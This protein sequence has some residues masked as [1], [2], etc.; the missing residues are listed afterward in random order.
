[1]LAALLIVSIALLTV[2]FGEGASGPI[3]TIQR[4][5]GSVAAPIEKGANRALK[6]ARDLFGW[7][8][9]SVTAKGDNDEL[10]TEV[11]ELRTR[12]AEAQDQRSEN[13]KLREFVGLRKRPDFPKDFKTAAGRVI[14]RSPTVWHSSVTI[15]VGSDDGVRT[16]DPVIAGEGLVGRI[17]SVN[18]GSS[19]IEL[20]TDSDSAVSALVTPTEG[21]DTRVGGVVR[22]EVGD[23]EDMLVEFIDKGRKIRKDWLVTTAGWKSGEFGSL[24]PQG[25]PIGRVTRASVSEQDTYQR[26]HFK[27]FV[28]LRGLEV[29]Q[30]LIGSGSGGAGGNAN[31]LADAQAGSGR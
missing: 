15:D 2:S 18:G 12:L 17:S 29:V 30:V 20:I 1:M 8:D 9:D 4:G 5:L 6:P 22:P 19:V 16:N 7:I 31:A 27:P 26:V 14:S 13:A 23:P 10:R 24:Y 3:S 11:T 21:S 28:D 25:I